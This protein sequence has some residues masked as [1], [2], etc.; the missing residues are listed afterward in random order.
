MPPA[1]ERT[2]CHGWC[3]RFAMGK[4][5]STVELDPAVY[6]LSMQRSESRRARYFA[7]RFQR[8]SDCLRHVH[9]ELRFDLF[10]EISRAC[11]GLVWQSHLTF[12]E[13]RVLLASFPA[14]IASACS[15]ENQLTQMFFWDSILSLRARYDFDPAV[16]AVAVRVMQEQLQSPDPCLAASAN[17]GIWGLDR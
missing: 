2:P 11:E 4:I 17:Y 3:D 5:R 9:P 7:A 8:A 13:K 6:P 12:N 15:F 14:L 1:Q 10:S 16:L